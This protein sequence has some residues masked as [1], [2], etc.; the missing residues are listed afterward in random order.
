VIDREQLDH[1]L[2][3]FTRNVD[4]LLRR[5]Q[6]EFYEEWNVLAKL[7]SLIDGRVLPVFY[8]Y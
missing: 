1:A 4:T 3:L 2:M 7:S 5:R 6:V 8:L